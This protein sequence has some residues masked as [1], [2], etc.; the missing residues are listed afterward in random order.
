MSSSIVAYLMLRVFVIH[1]L[2]FSFAVLHH[3]SISKHL[4]V[5]N[6]ILDFQLW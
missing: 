6:R 4:D 5:I 2:N 3:L 1:S